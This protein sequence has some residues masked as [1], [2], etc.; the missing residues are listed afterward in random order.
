[1]NVERL[2]NLTA[3]VTRVVRDGTEDAFGDP[4]ETTL[5]ATYRCWLAQAGADEATVNQDVQREDF[6][7]YLEAGA[8]GGIDGTDRVTVGGVEYEVVGPPWSAINPRTG[9]T[10]HV[11]ATI[12]RTV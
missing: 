9:Q 5:T 10:T 7:L 6:A 2:L 8:S 12:R 11:V 4:T 1:V 3:S